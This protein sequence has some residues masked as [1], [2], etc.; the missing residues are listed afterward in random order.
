MKTKKISFEIILLIVILAL[1]A[2]VA[3][4]PEARIL[5][6]FQTDDAFY[7]FVT[8]RNI[9]E[10]RGIT[11]DGISA[12]NGFHPLW[13]LICVSVFSLAKINLYLPLRIIIMILALFN[14]A[15][16]ILLYR[17]FKRKFSKETGWFVAIFWTFLPTIHELTSK[18]GLESGLTAF[19]LV[20][21]ISYLSSFEERELKPKNF[22]IMSLL[23]ILLLF[24][25]LDM[26]F[27]VI[28]MGIWLVFRKTTLRWQILLDGLIGFLS[29]MSAYYLR[30][31]NTNNIFNFLPFLYIFLVLSLVSK[32]AFQ[33]ALKG[34]VC[35][36]S[37]PIKK[38]VLRSVLGLGISSVFTLGVIFLLHDVLHVFLGFPRTV[39]IIDFVISLFLMLGWRFAYIFYMLSKNRDYSEDI[40]WSKNGKTWLV[41]AGSYFGPILVLLVAYM[42]FNNAYAGSYLPISGT[43]KRWWGTLPLTVYGQPLKTLG[44]VLGSW[45]N[46]TTKEGPWWLITA[47]VNLLIEV[48]ARATGMPQQSLAFGNFKRDF[49]VLTW[50]LVLIFVAW[51]IYKKKGFIQKAMRDTAFF[52][53][54]VGCVIHLFNYKATGYLHAKYWYWIPEILCTVMFFGIL[55]ESI[56]RRYKR[57]LHGT[58]ASQLLVGGFCLILIF[59]LA[60]P[61]LKQ[62]SYQKGD[63]S[64]HQYILETKFV[65]VHTDPGDIIGMTGGGVI[66][67]FIKDRT[68][69]NL[70]GLINGSEYF[71]ELKNGQ[72]YQYLDAIG[73]DYV[74]AAEPMILESDPYG[75]IFNGRLIHLDKRGQFDFYRYVRGVVSPDI[76][77]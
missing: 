77:P 12:T 41:N 13:M 2:F 35:D 14:A 55:V 53:L 75:W 23:G 58:I 49:G 68:I 8:A 51:L 34:Y 64:Q 57:Y 43:I 24:S 32:I 42:L 20:A 22:L 46:P 66:A 18:L 62:Y 4:A 74:Y 38:Q 44:G 3:F 21:A 67:Y 61:M 70:D 69:V 39:L 65:E 9:A 40:S 17:F 15:T 76:N 31:Q 45:F 19:A 48:V 59:N 1:H 26:I 47:P 25:R 52:P 56:V 33:Y 11:F 27:I 30:V 60:V 73:L 63:A 72:A 29:A 6:W 16:G 54:F 5:N 71:E 50:T 36:S 37:A 10:G 7:Y 28:I